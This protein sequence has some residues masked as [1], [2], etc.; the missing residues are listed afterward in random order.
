M[1][2]VFHLQ[3]FHTYQ[4]F[5]CLHFWFHTSNINIFIFY[6]R[7]H[8]IWVMQN[9]VC[10]IIFFLLKCVLY[11][12]AYTVGIKAFAHWST[13]EKMKDLHAHTQWN[14]RG[15]EFITAGCACGLWRDNVHA[16]RHVTRRGAWTLSPHNGRRDRVVSSSVSGSP[17]PTAGW[18]PPNASQ[19]KGDAENMVESSWIE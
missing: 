15:W 17:T 1:K 4:R 18:G 14:M 13:R 11:D 6:H 8:S 5:S 16:L 7:T 12:I 19:C 10:Y 3:F 2:F 9:V